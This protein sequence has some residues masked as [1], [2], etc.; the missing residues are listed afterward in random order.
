MN[1]YLLRRA[2]RTVRYAQRNLTRAT[3]EEQRAQTQ[4]AISRAIIRIF[5]HRISK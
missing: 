1:S 2:R 4:R 5:L 3:T